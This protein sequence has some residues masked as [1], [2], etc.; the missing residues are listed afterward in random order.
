[1]ANKFSN[2][3]Q[4]MNSSVFCVLEKVTFRMYNGVGVP[5]PRGTGTSGYVEANLVATKT[6]YNKHTKHQIKTP[7]KSQTLLEHERRREVELKCLELKN[8]LIKKGKSEEQIKRIVSTYREN[9]LNPPPK[10]AILPK[11]P[12]NENQN[13]GQKVE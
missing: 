4:E 12:N 5:T 9:Q 10:D 1:M 13:E 11:I 6:K 3:L 7:K 2:E 8:E